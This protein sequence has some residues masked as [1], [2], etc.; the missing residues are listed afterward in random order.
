MGRPGRPTVAIELSEEE[1]ETLQRWARRHSSSQA[2]A[3]RCRIVLG[4]AEGEH[5]QGGRRAAGGQPGHGRE[6]A[7]AVR[8]RAAGRAGG[9]AA[10]RGGRAR[11]PTRWS[12]RSWSRRWRRAPTDAT[13]WST[14]SLAAATRD[15]PADGQRDLAG[16]R[17]EAVAA[18]R[19]Q[20]LPGPGADREDPRPG[21]PL[22]VPA[23]RRRGLRRRR[24]APDP[25]A[26]PVRADPADAAHHAAASDPR[27]RPQRHPG[28]VRR[29]GHRD[30]EGDQRPP[31]VP[32]RRKTSSPS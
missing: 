18:R 5:Q 24:E 15:Q 8:R 14:R 26:E 2:L 19:V 7:A 4:V 16:L 28:P 13:H 21:R 1:R 17:A 9:R 11:S 29:L 23:G 3:L 20:G 30:R 27:L 31:Q 12:R 32:H 22:P 10:A 6:V 25:G